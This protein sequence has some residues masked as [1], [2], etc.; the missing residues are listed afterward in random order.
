M[1][2]RRLPE[3]NMPTCMHLAGA[4][5]PAA[6]LVAS[7]VTAC[8]ST[9]CSTARWCRA[10]SPGS[11]P[12]G[13]ARRCGSGVPAPGAAVEEASRSALNEMPKASVELSPGLWNA[14]M[15]QEPAVTLRQQELTCSA[16]RPSRRR[17]S[18]TY[19]STHPRANSTAEEC[20][21]CSCGK[22]APSRN[23]NQLNFD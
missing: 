16:R 8:C 12:S 20:K 5:L 4:C 2:L 1:R 11:C 13:A 17:Q 3:C 19:S 18:F 9:A 10:N 15:A 6:S 7:M 21:S 14:A 22:A 23:L